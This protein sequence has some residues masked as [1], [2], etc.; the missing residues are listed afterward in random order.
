MSRKKG[1]TMNHIDYSPNFDNHPLDET[2]ENYRHI[3]DDEE[4]WLALKGE[5]APKTIGEWVSQALAKQENET[6]T[7]AIEDCFQRG[8]KARRAHQSILSDPE[9]Q[10]A[11]DEIGT[12]L[13]GQPRFTSAGIVQR[14]ATKNN[15]SG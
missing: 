6:I 10:A 11:I 14:T 1:P 9:V 2:E 15:P 7:A 3:E 4:L 5:D 13:A 12:V 8:L